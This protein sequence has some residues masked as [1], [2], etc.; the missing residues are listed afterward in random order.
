MGRNGVVERL[1]ASETRMWSSL[2]RQPRYSSVNHIKHGHSHPIESTHPDPIGSAASLGVLF[3][4]SFLY[5]FDLVACSTL[6]P[7]HSTRMSIVP[8]LIG[9][10]DEFASSTFAVKAPS[11][12]EVCWEASSV[13]EQDARRVADIA[14][15]AFSTWATTKPRV[16]QAILFRA[17]DLME[18][19][20][21]ELVS[22]MCTEMGAD[23]GTIRQL[24]V[25]LATTMMRD[26]ACRIL[27]VCG[28][29]PQSEAGGESCMVW[30]EPYGVVLGIVPW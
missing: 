6:L 27:D 17:A 22:C 21:D 24:I 3:C 25:G 26:I 28:T 20:A 5:R 23:S 2:T 7:S 19:R 9:G 4:K 11:T 29:V 10:Q 1:R 12:G 13:S 15:A 30:K 16:R 14:Q 8:S 18:E